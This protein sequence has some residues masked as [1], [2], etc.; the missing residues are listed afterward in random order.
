MKQN[1]VGKII[2][3]ILLSAIFMAAC[4]WPS[5]LRA[6]SLSSDVIG[7]FPKNVGEFAYADLRAARAFSWFPQLQ[8]QMLPARFK[9]FESFLAAAGIDPNSQVEELV[10]ALVPSGM[11]TGATANTA[12]PKADEVIGVAL[13][14]FRPETA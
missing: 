8:E 7:M 5:M 2:K 9:Q 11:P 4:A 13:G 1:M 10:W 12:V 3:P 6:N 14:T